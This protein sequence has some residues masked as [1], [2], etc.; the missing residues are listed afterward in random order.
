MNSDHVEK[1]SYND[2]RTRINN[3]I[4]S[5]IDIIQLNI[6]PYRSKSAR[7]L[8]KRNKVYYTYMMISLYFL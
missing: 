2:F 3:F 8:V 5:M 7:K 4:D 6:Y 1:I